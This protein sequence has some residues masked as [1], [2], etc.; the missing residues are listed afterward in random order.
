MIQ[1]NIPNIASIINY[2]FSSASCHYTHTYF[3][4]NSKL[5]SPM[6]CDLRFNLVR[7]SNA[8]KCKNQTNIIL[9]TSAALFMNPPTFFP[10]DSLEILNYHNPNTSKSKQ[11][12]ASILFQSFFRTIPSTCLAEYSSS[13][14]S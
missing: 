1:L 6:N 12:K 13:R 14:V 2:N 3:L 11:S 8:G 4:Y 9:N 5:P 7:E 10:P